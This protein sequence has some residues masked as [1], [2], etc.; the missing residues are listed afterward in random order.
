MEEYGDGLRVR[1]GGVEQQ[2]L[3]LYFFKHED[4]KLLLRR[5]RNFERVWFVLFTSRF[6]SWTL[7]SFRLGFKRKIK[8]FFDHA[9]SFNNNPNSEIKL[10][11]RKNPIFLSS[12]RWKIDSST[13]GEFLFLMVVNVTYRP[14]PLTSLTPRLQSK[15]LPIRRNIV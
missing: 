12:F 1:S 10:C 11:R 4:F 3:K 9:T 2:K 15:K 7:I 8:H 13:Y 6:E 5:L 14:L